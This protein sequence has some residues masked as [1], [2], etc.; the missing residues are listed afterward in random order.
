MLESTPF[1]PGGRAAPLNHR[2]STTS[3]VLATAL[4][5]VG[6]SD[7]APAADERR[8]NVLLISIDSLRADHLSCYGYERETSPEIDR[9]ASEGILF[10][11]AVSSTSWTLPAHAAAFTGLPDSVHRTERPSSKLSAEHR[12]LAEQLRDAGYTTAGFWSGPFLAPTFGMDQGFDV[13]V[14][15][16]TPFEVTEDE[17]AGRMQREINDASHE[18]VTSPRLLEAVT[19]WL[20]SVPREPFFL[21]VHMWDVHYDYIPPPPYDT[22]YDPDYDGPADGRNVKNTL[23]GK[24]ARDIEHTIALYDGEIAWT[25][26]HV[27]DMLRVLEARGLAEHTVVILM[28]DHGEEFFEHGRFGHRKTL[29]E[30]SVRIP[31][32]VRLPGGAGA[33]ERRDQVASIMDVAPTILAL[34]GAPPL[35]TVAGRPLL[36]LD[37]HAGE[38]RDLALSEI[39]RK[40]PVE[41]G[42]MMA[43]RGDGWKLVA[44][45]RDGSP[46]QL[47]DLSSDPGEQHDRLEDGGALAERALTALAE[48]R[49][50]L[51]TLR[52]LHAPGRD[53]ESDIPAEMEAE[54]RSLGYIGEDD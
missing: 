16:R 14:D 36:A 52:E 30:E 19:A 2:P 15:C 51:E 44:R 34:A 9:L 25:D 1:A 17:N 27:G 13:Y 12:T 31:L 48:V 41:I 28:A 3:L 10:E 11:N 18:D 33:G 49:E 47:F 23:S 24:N 29:F 37:G 22:L 35:T 6:C 8:P 40:E 32:I 46:L 5:A 45:R 7:P 39:W 53:R 43:L 26:R 20:G 42:P 21:F 4:A 38:R 50:Q 54:L